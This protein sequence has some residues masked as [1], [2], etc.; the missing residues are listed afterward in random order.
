MTTSPTTKGLSDT[1]YICHISEIVSFLEKYYRNNGTKTS[2]QLFGL[3]FSMISQSSQQLSVFIT[4][5]KKKLY[6][7]TMQLISVSNSSKSTTIFIYHGRFFS[8]VFCIY[9]YSIWSKQFRENLCKYS[10]I[11]H[12]QF[13]HRVVHKSP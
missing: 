3:Y 4:S 7:T 8:N 13:S 11:K 9:I 6:C 5:H 10:R 12:Y 1:C 2:L